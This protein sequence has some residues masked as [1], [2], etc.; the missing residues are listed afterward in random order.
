MEM[1]VTINTNDPEQFGEVIDDLVNYYNLLYAAELSEETEAAE[2]MTGTV[3]LVT[4]EELE[5]GLTTVEAEAEATNTK[6][7]IMPADIPLPPAG[8]EVD[9]EGLPWD[10]RI[11]AKSKAKLKKDNTWKLARGVEKGL[12]DKVKNELRAAMNTPAP[13]LDGPG[14]GTNPETY[15]PGDNLDPAAIFGAGD[16]VPPNGVVIPPVPVTTNNAPEIPAAPNT[17]VQE[18]PKTATFPDLVQKVTTR[19]TDANHGAA[20][21][22]AVKQTLDKYQLASMPLL[23]SRPDLVP[24]IDAELETAWNTLNTQ[25]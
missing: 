10:S 6:Q 14:I 19:I 25:G 5:N 4:Q 20:F 22:A 17:P 2:E 21:N 15:E 24:V 9:S 8:V 16:E 18:Q 23:V 13:V 12:V 1:I 3:E 11:H 7:V